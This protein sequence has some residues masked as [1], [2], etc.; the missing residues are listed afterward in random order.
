MSLNKK[1]TGS[2]LSAYTLAG[3]ILALLIITFLLFVMYGVIPINLPN[4]LTTVFLPSK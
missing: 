1:A 4:P 2:S 3:I